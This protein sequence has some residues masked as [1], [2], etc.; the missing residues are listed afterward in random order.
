[1]TPVTDP[2]QCAWCDAA[3]SLKARVG[4]EAPL[5]ECSCCAKLT[6]VDEKNLAYRAEPRRTDVSG[7]MIEG[8]DY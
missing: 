1:M 4:L 6:R 2:P 5:Y 7:H 8:H 3:D